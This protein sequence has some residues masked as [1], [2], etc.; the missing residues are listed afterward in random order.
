MEFLCDVLKGGGHWRSL[1]GCEEE[2]RG[3]CT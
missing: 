2:E 1:G 3:V